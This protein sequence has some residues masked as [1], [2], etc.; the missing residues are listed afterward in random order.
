[1]PVSE[2]ARS[3][4]MTSALWPWNDCSIWPDSTS[5]RAHVESPEPV[6]ICWS[7]LGKRQHD[8]YD[9]CVP[10]VLRRW[11]GSSS[12]LNGY[13]VTLLSRPLRV[14]R[15]NSCLS[16]A[17]LHSMGRMEL[18]SLNDR[19]QVGNDFC[20]GDSNSVPEMVAGHFLSSFVFVS[21]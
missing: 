15:L 17:M 4:D 7:E 11:L 9:V 3:M 19:L 16:I 5:Q 21:I 8:M 14:V 12:M 1:M 10:T 2:G 20:S 6:R 13:T 18:F